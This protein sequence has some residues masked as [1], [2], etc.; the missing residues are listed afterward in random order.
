MPCAF[1]SGSTLEGKG[2]A[3]SMC[4]TILTSYLRRCL[5]PVRDFGPRL[6]ALMAG[7]G[8]TT[9]TGHN[10]WWFW[11]AW[12][13]TISGA[14]TG[15]CLYD[16]FIFIGGES[17]INYAP[18]RRRRAKLKK[19]SKW[20]KRLGIGKEKVPSLEEGVKNLED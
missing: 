4:L 1:A 8:G 15:A 2:S 20:R 5:N 7:Y 19:E 14:L 11:G 6:V 18:R 9:F 16:V 3:S 17:P 12:V 13:A 10:G